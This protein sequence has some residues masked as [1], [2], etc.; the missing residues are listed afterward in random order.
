M[1]ALQVIAGIWLTGSL[2]LGVI[3]LLTDVRSKES[4]RG[5]EAVEQWW[6]FGRTGW[7]LVTLW[8]VVVL[9]FIVGCVFV[10]VLML[11]A[12]PPEPPGDELSERRR[13]R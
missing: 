8:P 3:F 7:I 11:R 9:G 1:I 12:Q 6:P 10:F 4:Y 2:F 5:P 13:R